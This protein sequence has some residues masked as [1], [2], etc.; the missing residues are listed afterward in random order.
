MPITASGV[1]TKTATQLIL[2][3]THSDLAVV[4]TYAGAAVNAFDV[5]G[6][7]TTTYTFPGKGVRLDQT[8]GRT[9]TK[10]T[11]ASTATKTVLTSPL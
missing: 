7:F 5:E 6:T 1:V 11:A 4:E 9:F 3:V 2:T 8:A 10:D